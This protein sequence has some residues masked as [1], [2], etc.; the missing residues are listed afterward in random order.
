[1]ASTSRRS[2]VNHPD[3]FCYIC[4][5]YTLKESRKPIS[6]FVKRCYVAYFG[7]HLGDQDKAWGPH[8]VCKTCVEHLRQWANG[9]RKCLKFGLSMVWGE[10]RNHFDDCYFCIVNI[11]GINRNNRHKWTY[12]DLNSAKRPVPHSDE[13][14]IPSFSSLPR[15]RLLEDKTESSTSPG[16]EYVRSDNDSDF[17][18]DS[19]KPQR[20]NQQELND[21]CRDLNLS[22]ESS[23]L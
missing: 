5:E 10:P 21:L 3:V 23:G 19:D 20:F 15:P 13:I 8:L 14:P 11:K 6:D 17:E 16:D 9:K 7:V 12:P 22:K 1:M 4:G 2:G 18:A